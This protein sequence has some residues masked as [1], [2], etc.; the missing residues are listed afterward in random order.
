MNISFLKSNL[1]KYSI[2]SGA[3]ILLSASFPAVAFQGL[4]D[5]INGKYRCEVN[6]YHH[7]CYRQTSSI[8]YF[9]DISIGAFYGILGSGSLILGYVGLM[10]GIEKLDLWYNKDK[11]PLLKKRYATILENNLEKISFDIVTRN[12]G[13]M[14]VEEYLPRLKNDL[15]KIENWMAEF[16]KNSYITTNDKCEITYLSNNRNYLGWSSYDTYLSN[17]TMYE[18]L[19]TAFLFLLSNKQTKTSELYLPLEPIG[20]Y[21]ERWLNDGC[22]KFPLFKKRYATIL[23]NNLENISFDIVMND[24]KGITLG[25]YSLRLEKDLQKIADWMAEFKKNSKIETNDTYQSNNTMYEKLHTAF[26]LLSNAQ[27]IKNL[28]YICH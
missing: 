14:K 20:K 25:D 7:R 3:L 9:K 22:L 19:H 11:F 1:R 5:Y 21:D 10:Y 8:D 17:K 26:L 18:K 4:W 13:T 16:E 6:S 15:K 28:D 12:L 27:P 23:E 24:I 2:I